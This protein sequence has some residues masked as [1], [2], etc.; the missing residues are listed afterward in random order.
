MRAGLPPRIPAP[1]E[2]GARGHSIG[3][4]CPERVGPAATIGPRGPGSADA[5]AADAECVSGDAVDTRGDGDGSVAGMD[6]D[7]DSNGMSASPGAG[8]AAVVRG[9][10]RATLP[11]RGVSTSGGTG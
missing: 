2:D 3:S 7:R 4:A 9:T 10:S 6:D 8:G 1:L 5:G 11:G